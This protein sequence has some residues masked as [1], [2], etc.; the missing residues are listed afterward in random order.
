[1]K[2]ILFSHG[3]GVKKDSRGLFS[4]ITDSLPQYHAVMFNYNS[5]K[6]HKSY[7]DSY[8]V[9]SFKLM[10]EIEGI[11]TTD[12]N[13]EIIIIGHSQ[14]CIMPCLVDLPAN[15]KKVILL[16]PPSI[17]ATK[18]PSS[19]K[20]GTRKSLTG[21]I[22]IPRKDGTTTVLTRAF[23][24]GLKSTDPIKLYKKTANIMPV[25]IISAKQDEMLVDANLKKL[26]NTA[27]FYSING[28]HNFTGT[29]RQGLVKLIS[30]ILS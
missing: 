5:T 23:L 29:D 7:V 14:G 22:L 8:K 17:L 3:F 2:Y 15:V 30:K 28:D 24:R 16:A 4:A 18:R 11:L 26:V 21:N 12:K 20:P 13:A 19:L 27:K 1:M 9:Q 10:K 25:T 6:G